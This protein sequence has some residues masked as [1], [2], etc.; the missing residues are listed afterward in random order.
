MAGRKLMKLGMDI[1]QLKIDHF[2]YPTLGE[3]KETVA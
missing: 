1:M 3:A 2:S